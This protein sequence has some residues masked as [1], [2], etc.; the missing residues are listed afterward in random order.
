MSQQQLWEAGNYVG[1]LVEA[2]FGKSNKNTPQVVFT[3]DIEGN[4]KMV[5]AYLSD[6]AQER[7]FEDLEKM[8]WNGSTSKPEFSNPKRVELYM[9]HDTYEGKTNEKWN[10]S[11]GGF[12][13]QPMAQDEMR[14]I[15][16]LYRNRGGK[17]AP[18]RPAP[19]RGSPAPSRPTPAPSKPAPSQQG[20][21]FSK[22]DAWALFEQAGKT[23][24][25]FFEVISGV[26]TEKGLS[27]SKFTAAEW[28]YVAGTAGIPF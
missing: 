13:P 14:R 26:E 1:D 10:I 28:R 15:E 25:D 27:E 6:A 3:F 5:F 2:V 7:T 21:N 19:S 11:S 16:A 9:Q 12:K 23:A 20:D 22:D 17:T 24:N 18:S 4:R 8:G